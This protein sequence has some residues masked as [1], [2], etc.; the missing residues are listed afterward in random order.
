MSSPSVQQAVDSLKQGQVIAYPTDTLFGLGVDA[1]NEEAI[2]YLYLIKQRNKHRPMS[3]MVAQNTWHQWVKNTS[4]HAEQLA[5]RF[6]PGP[7]TLIM[8]A[9]KDVPKI[10]TRYTN[11][12]IGVRVPDHP[13]CLAL[14]ENFQNP[15][16]TTSANLSN[17]P[18]ARNAEMIR[19]YFDDKVSYILSDGPKPGGIASTVVDVTEDEPVVLREGAIPEF[20]IWRATQ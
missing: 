6:F 4:K 19:N 8:N 9:G 7:I 18:A 14:L 16:I 13:T 2:E 5:E 11:G 17:Q 10:L 20:A 1:L 3:I 15:I 12:T